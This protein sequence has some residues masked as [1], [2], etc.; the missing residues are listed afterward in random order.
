VARD[1]KQT[2]L[3]LLSTVTK[4]NASETSKPLAPTFSPTEPMANLVFGQ[5]PSAAAVPRNSQVH[6]GNIENWQAVVNQVA[7]GIGARV[8]DQ[9]SEARLQLNPP[10]LGRLDIQL[11]VEGERVQAHI[12]AE[13]KDVGALIQSHLPELKQALQSHRLDLENL[14][15]DVQTSGDNLNSSSQQFRQEARSS[16]QGQFTG[17]SPINEAEDD[18]ARPVAPLQPPGRIS[19]WA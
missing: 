11:I 18:I 6:S 1:T 10:E 4:E 9:S 15:V 13:S 7:D 17:V 8:Q 2:E 19:V 16:G 5:T 3:S 14:R 12:V